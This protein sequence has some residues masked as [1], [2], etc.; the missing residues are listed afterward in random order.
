MSEALIGLLHLVALT[1]RGIRQWW[2]AM[3]SAVLDPEPR[4][5]CQQC[6]HYQPEAFRCANHRAAGLASDEISPAL[7]AVLQHCPG[8]QT[9]DDSVQHHALRR[10]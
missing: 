4:V 9:R 6:A 1:R 5:T 3:Q 7:A 8:F 10:A 2:P